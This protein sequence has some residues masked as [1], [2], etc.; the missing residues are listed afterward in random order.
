MKFESGD[1]RRPENTLSDNC[2]GNCVVST[3]DNKT[4]LE[5]TKRAVDVPDSLPGLEIV[6]LVSEKETT[7]SSSESTLMALK[8]TSP[9]MGTLKPPPARQFDLPKSPNEIRINPGE[10]LKLPKAADGVRVEFNQRR[11]Q[12]TNSERYVQEAAHPANVLVDGLAAATIDF[13]SPTQS[14]QSP[15]GFDYVRVNKM[16][17]MNEAKPAQANNG[18]MRSDDSSSSAVGELSARQ[19]YAVPEQGK[20]L[21]AVFKDGIPVGYGQYN[22]FEE[23]VNSLNPPSRSPGTIG[24]VSG[25]LDAG[26]RFNN[27]GTSVA[28]DAIAVNSVSGLETTGNITFSPGDNFSATAKAWDAYQKARLA[29]ESGDSP[30]I[31]RLRA[32]DMLVKEMGVSGP[33][34][35][36]ADK[37]DVERFNQV[38]E[39]DSNRNRAI[40]LVLPDDWRES[41]TSL[42]RAQRDRVSQNTLME[43]VA[44][45]INEEVA[46]NNTYYKAISDFN[47]NVKSPPISL[48]SENQRLVVNLDERGLP[49]TVAAT[50]DMVRQF[51]QELNGNSNR[52]RAAWLG[53][54]T[55]ERDTFMRLSTADREQLVDKSRDFE[56]LR[57]ELPLTAGLY[58]P[59][60]LVVDY[61]IPQL[62]A[63]PGSD[64]EKTDYN[65]NRQYPGDIPKTFE[66]GE[67]KPGESTTANPPPAVL[68]EFQPQPFKLPP[69]PDENPGYTRLHQRNDL[70]KTEHGFFPSQAKP[71]NDEDEIRQPAETNPTKHEKPPET[72]PQA[73][74][75][76]PENTP[77]NQSEA[78][79]GDTK[80]DSAETHVNSSESSSEVEPSQEN[81]SGSRRDLSEMVEGKQGKSGQE[82]TWYALGDGTGVKVYDQNP[83]SY[84]LAI[85]SFNELKSRGYPVPEIIETGTVNGYPA[86]RMQ[87]IK[88]QTVREALSSI[89]DVNELKELVQK[90]DSLIDKA[91]SDKIMFDGLALPNMIWNPETK[92]ITIVDPSA[93]ASTNGERPPDALE[94]QDAKKELLE[95]REQ[96]ESATDNWNV[97]ANEL[98]E[99]QMQL[100][101]DFRH[102]PLDEQKHVLSEMTMFDSLTN[103]RKRPTPDEAKQL[104]EMA[105]HLVHT[106][107]ENVII[108]TEKQREE[109][110]VLREFE[111]LPS[112]EQSDLIGE[113]AIEY[114]Q[115]QDPELRNL[116][117]K[118]IEAHHGQ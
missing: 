88:G 52:V 117:H 56:S 12:S 31:E 82:G 96:T 33:I 79:A 58:A 19:A 59:S 91:T 54:D 25:Q 74:A 20:E 107:P 63:E 2:F 42:S 114:S 116:L 66:P 118:L 102:L 99:E 29:I 48:L 69:Q 51:N 73:S 108:L 43:G 95:Y 93:I 6:N 109:L 34:Y 84:E 113:L 83:E 55:K 46:A 37:N 101:R 76:G 67:Q 115:N 111:H 57:R 24:G 30:A 15:D 13:Y 5:Q 40:Y 10:P 49:I 90:Y 110:Q 32:G 14:V 1:L 78:S 65:P 72:D 68:K 112:N 62:P 64:L 81:P 7:K 60:K 11:P 61:Q 77:A 16:S 8:L 71:L 53:L 18:Q 27:L 106:D 50:P 17:W 26:A 35:K 47:S 105:V 92:E 39:G 100:I 21:Y 9:N 70:E 3:E 36:E 75:N 23:L 38:F 103:V 94:I 87:E 28:P 86:I 45:T 97:P 41:Y 98:T 44:R 22:S 89:T 104:S 4:Y 85:E 80:E